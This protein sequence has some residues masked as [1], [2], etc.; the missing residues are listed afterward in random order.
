MRLLLLLPVWGCNVEFVASEV[1]E[2]R[3]HIHKSALYVRDLWARQFVSTH[4][5]THIHTHT[6]THTH[7]HVYIRIPTYTYIYIIHTEDL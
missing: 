6:H 3:Q 5:N 1:R 4:S 2:K 7:T